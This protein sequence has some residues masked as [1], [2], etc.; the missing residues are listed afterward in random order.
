MEDMDFVFYN[1]LHVDI[2]F[3]LHLRH[4]IVTP[5]T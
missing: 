4:Y 5:Y 1:N 2:Y 3:N